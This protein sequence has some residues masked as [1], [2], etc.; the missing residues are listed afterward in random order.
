VRVK[1]ASNEW[2]KE[3]KRE[4]PNYHL[5]PQLPTSINMKF[6]AAALLSLATAASAASPAC[7]GESG[8]PVD[9]FV[10]VKHVSN[11]ICRPCKDV[12]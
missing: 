10:V 6:T 9:W 11:Q 7:I 8:K 5:I 12:I 3:G 1:F 2:T 4:D